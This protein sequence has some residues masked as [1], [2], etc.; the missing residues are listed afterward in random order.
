MG[1][2][3]RALRGELSLDE[4]VKVLLYGTSA[5]APEM[6]GE[7]DHDARDVLSMAVSLYRELGG[8]NQN[9][10]INGDRHRALV[11]PTVQS[12]WAAVGQVMALTESV[13]PHTP[14]FRWTVVADIL[15]VGP[16]SAVYH[17]KR[18]GWEFTGRFGERRV[19]FA[20]C[21]SCGRS[22][23]AKKLMAQL[24]PCCIDQA[25]A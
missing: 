8:L 10:G 9:I 19:V 13:W 7:W 12:S 22:W 18:L 4:S 17:F 3:Q 6:W 24:G 5:A 15:E 14:G 21:L 11:P 25:D 16:R 20:P 23:P 2:V 1:A